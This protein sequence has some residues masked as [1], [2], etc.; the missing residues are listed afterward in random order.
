MKAPWTHRPMRIPVLHK[1]LTP[2]MPCK[3]SKARKLL[4]DGKATKHW[5]KEGIFYIQLNW[6]STKHTQEVCLGID[7]GSKFDGFAVLTDKEILT[8]GMSILPD[9][10]KKIENRRIMRRG[11]RYRKTR[12]RECKIK[13]TKRDGWIS[14]SQDAKVN[15]RLLLVSKYLKLYPITCFA[16]EDVKFNHY[17]KRWGKYFSTVEIGKTKLYAEL[18]KLG[19]LFRFAGYQT[20]EFRD[21]EGLKKSSNKSELSFDSHAI[22]AAVIAS[23]VMGYT[24]DF[25]VPEFWVFKR[26]NLRRRSLHL[27]NFQKGGKRRVHGGTWALGIKKNTVCIW[28]GKV[29][30]TSGSTRGRLSLHDMS[31]KAKRVT[32][33]AKTEDLKLLYHQSIYAERLT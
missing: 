3:P 28:R 20:K 19:E 32:Q 21:R 12:R 27:Q 5:T 26:P 6:D 14:P 2:L 13:D 23:E 4:R 8:S 31:I 10:R 24:G 15:F 29:Y 18:E 33:N 17:K 1:N 7:P 9:I 22:D 16:V 11:R 25:S 30:R